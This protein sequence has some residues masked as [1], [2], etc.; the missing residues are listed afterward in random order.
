MA[1]PTTDPAAEG[2]PRRVKPSIRKSKSSDD[3]HFSQLEKRSQDRRGRR[4]PTKD[5]KTEQQRHNSVTLQPKRSNDNTPKARSP[6]RRANSFTSTSSGTN[7]EIVS[8]KAPEVK[9]SSSSMRKERKLSLQSALAKLA[10]D[11]L[12]SHTATDDPVEDVD[13]NDNNKETNNS[14]HKRRSDNMKLKRRSNSKGRMEARQHASLSVIKLSS[15]SGLEAA[16]KTKKHD[17]CSNITTKIIRPA[18]AVEKRNRRKP[19]SRHK[20]FDVRS[21]S[22]DAKLSLESGDKEGKEED[23]TTTTKDKDSSTTE[24]RPRNKK[25]PPRTAKSFHG[26][27]P[28]PQDGSGHRR[29]SDI[30]LS[31]SNTNTTAPKKK[32][33]KKP[34]KTVSFVES[35]NQ[36]E[37]LEPTNA[38]ELSARW[39][40]K[41]DLNTLLQHEIRICKRSNKLSCARGLERTLADD[42][43]KE[44]AQ[45]YVKTMLEAQVKLKK[46]LVEGTAEAKAASQAE[47]MR[48]FSKEQSKDDRQIAYKRGL[49]DASDVTM[50]KQ[51]QQQQQPQVPVE[52]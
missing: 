19:P 21:I 4:R 9:S 11:T 17:S 37:P 31:A 20:S 3:A 10:V 41:S 2:A 34:A 33:K 27:R 32:P 49:Q 25:L 23:D 39:Y 14:N 5:D 40:L 45:T 47:A 29:S 24:K 8:S 13:N 52:K 42:S 16:A 26:S 35:K 18:Q 7:L 1:H 6:L 46:A 15:S 44:H 48:L 30:T 12:P 22:E 43:T 28:I 51:Q 50:M 38:Q 36:V